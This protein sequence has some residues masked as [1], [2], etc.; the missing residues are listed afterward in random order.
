MNEQ[1]IDIK[2]EAD[3]LCRLERE[4]KKQNCSV[5][6]LVMRFLAEYLRKH[7]NGGT[8]PAHG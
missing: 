2:F 3:M 6:E 7:P 8:G 4:A 1:K 5:D